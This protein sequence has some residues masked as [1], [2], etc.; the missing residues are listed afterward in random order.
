MTIGDFDCCTR[1]TDC[2]WGVCLDADGAAL[3]D[4][5]TEVRCDDCRPCPC[6]P[7]ETA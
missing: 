7:E 4:H 5:C 6:Q 1:C 2:G 3:C